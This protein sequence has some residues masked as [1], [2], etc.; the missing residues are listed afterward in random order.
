MELGGCLVDEYRS[1]LVYTSLMPTIDA[2]IHGTMIEAHFAL[3]GAEGSRSGELAYRVQTSMWYLNYF[4]MGDM[5]IPLL[6]SKTKDVDHADRPCWPPYSPYDNWCVHPP[7]VPPKACLPQNI[8]DF[9]A[10]S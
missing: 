5:T 3:I 1:T 4:A 6:G 10:I 7:Y 8:P 9:D 2:G